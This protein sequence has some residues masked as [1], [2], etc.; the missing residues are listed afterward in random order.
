M[1]KRGEITTSEIGKAIL[2]L[3]ILA[4]FIAIMFPALKLLFEDTAG[5]GACKWELFLTTFSR[6]TGERSIPQSCRMQIHTITKENLTRRRADKLYTP[7]Q[8]AE[9]GMKLWWD[10]NRFGES[11]PYFRGSYKDTYLP[12]EPILYEWAAD[13]IVAERMRYCWDKVDQGNVQLFDNWYDVIDWH[14]FGYGEDAKPKPVWGNEQEAWETWFMNI[15]KPPV[16]C[17][18]CDQIKFDN[19]LQQMFGSRDIISLDEWMRNSP[20]PED[21]L[22]GSNRIASYYEYVTPQLGFFEP[23]YSYQMSEPQAVIYTRI[24]LWD[25]NVFNI[26][27]QPTEIID[28][29]VVWSGIQ[30]YSLA[31]DGLPKKVDRIHVIPYREVSARCNFVIS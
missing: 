22:A 2:S 8:E 19:D 23:K 6:I 24:P 10:D 27:E 4:F 30:I 15:K 21:V 5:A 7:V 9:R 29:F 12:D 16:L 3:V 1:K 28:D 26:I 11:A 31:R 13:K 25:V 20:L 17:I 18:I 14:I